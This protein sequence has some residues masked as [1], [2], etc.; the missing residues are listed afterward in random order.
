[1]AAHALPAPFQWRGEHIAIDLPGGAALFTTRRGGHSRGEYADCNLGGSV[2]DDPAA[3][4]ANRAG[5]A[6]Y[7][8]RPAAAF[9]FG[10][11][12]HGTHVETVHEPPA[13]GW[14]RGTFAALD[15]ADGQA[16]AL[17]R[18]PLVVITADCL[19]IALIGERAA[20]AVHAGWRGLAGGV[21][22]AAL[23][24]LGALGE[25]GPLRA[26]IGPA[27][28]ACCYEVGEEVHAS[29]Q[30]GGG[31]IREGRRID[32][33]AIAARELRRAGVADVHDCALC[34]ICA[35]ELFFSHRRQQG[36]A[37]RQCGVVWRS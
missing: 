8:G 37:G 10:A 35:P 3:V 18:V 20:A 7:V 4:A 32:L 31:S 11:Q 26:A 30:T 27:A 13:G 14:E 12:V 5:V 25:R 17:A 1:M 2:G 21:L 28:R 9:A 36:R 33:A 24:V 6:E 34:T 23:T 15:P 22:D 16:T 29:F 19:P